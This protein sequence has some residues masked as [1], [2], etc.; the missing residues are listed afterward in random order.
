MVTEKS[1]PI[2]FEDNYGVR[3]DQPSEHP[4][5]PI[6]PASPAAPEAP[7]SADLLL[8]PVELSMLSWDFHID[9]CTFCLSQ[10][11]E[12]CYEGQYLADRVED[13]RLRSEAPHP[14]R[15]PILAPERRP[16]F[17]GTPA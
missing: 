3:T 17:P 9:R 13:V 8:E 7:V 15:R 6:S 16:I 11:N 5:S 4:T 1:P 12:L 2:L 14:S 10:G